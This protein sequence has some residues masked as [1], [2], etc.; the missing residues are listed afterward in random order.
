VTRAAL[1]VDKA[2]LGLA[3]AI[4]ALRAKLSTTSSTVH[5]L[6]GRAH[7]FQRC[8]AGSLRPRDVG[9]VEDCAG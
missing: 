1:L 7:R 6:Q 9:V 2:I 8:S 4:E 3:E 5:H